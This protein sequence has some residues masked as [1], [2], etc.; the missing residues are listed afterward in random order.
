MKSKR[1]L[2]LIL[3]MMIAIISSGCQDDNKDGKEDDI[4]GDGYANTEP[5]PGCEGPLEFAD[6]EL[7]EEVRNAIGRPEGEIQFEDVD[8]LTEIHRHV[9]ISDLTGIQCLVNLDTLVLA[10]NVLEDISPLAGLTNLTYLDLSNGMYI[11]DISAL[12]GLTKLTYIELGSN[13]ISD[14]SPL[15]K[16]TNLTFLELLE[17]SISDISPL[18]KLTNLTSL[19][20]YYNNISDISPLSSLANL[21]ELD[22]NYNS[23]TDISALAAL[24]NLTKLY[25]DENSITDISP[26]VANEGVNNGDEVSIF[27]NPLDC[28]DEATLGYI[29]TLEDRGVYISHDCGQN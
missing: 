16:L 13:S 25:L 24:T 2:L 28:E 5:P 29:A 15:A 22:L 4:T 1:T 9:G 19:D 26:L 21:T 6:P 18:V 20:L 23:I 7:E 3:A 10:N 14:I 8:G 17:N 12:A 27:G 11:S